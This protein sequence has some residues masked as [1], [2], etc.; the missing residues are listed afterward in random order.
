MTFSASQFTTKLLLKMQHMQFAYL[1]FPKNSLKMFSRYRKT[2]LDKEDV[3]SLR[4]G[5]WTSTYW[6]QWC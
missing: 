4:S 6:Q 5:S 3:R 2:D 1:K